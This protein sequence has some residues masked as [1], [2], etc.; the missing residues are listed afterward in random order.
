MDKDQFIER[1]LTGEAPRPAT[2]SAPGAPLSVFSKAGIPK[3]QRS[4][5][6]SRPFAQALLEESGFGSGET[7]PR[8]ELVLGD[9][10]T[11]RFLPPGAT[12][13][14]KTEAR[15]FHIILFQ[16][17][18]KAREILE[19]AFF[20]QWDQLEDAV[21]RILQDALE[22][23][24]RGGGGRTADRKQGAQTVTLCVV[25]V[26][27]DRG[28]GPARQL[29]CFGTK[30]VATN[31][32]EVFTLRE[33]ARDWA[34]RG[35]KALAVEH[36]GQLFKR[37]FEPLTQGAKWQDAFVSGAERKKAAALV[38]A[39][40]QPKLFGEAEDTLRRAVRDLL[41]EIAWSFGLPRRKANQN[42]CLDTVDLPSNH[43]IAVDPDESRRPGFENP[44]SGMRVYDASE[45]LLGFIVYFPKSKADIERLQ[46]E[47]RTHNHF[48]N[49]LVIYPG[50]DG[51]ELELW[52]GPDPLRGRLVAGQRRSRFDGEGGI[53]QLFSR[54]FVVSKSAIDTPAQLA[55]ELAWRG[56]HLKALA[57]EELARE[58]EKGSGPLKKLF[59]VFNQALATLTVNQFADA[60]A[61][62]ITYGMLAARWL[63]TEGTTLLFTRKNLADLLPSTSAFLH[64]LFQR[65]VNSNFDK[66][67]SWLLDDITSLLA[68]TSVAQVFQGEQDPSI[69]FYQDFLDAYDP[70][71]RKDQGVYYTPDEVVSYIVRTAHAA[72]QEQFG[73]PLGLADTTTWADFAKAKKLR[74]PDGVPPKE[75]FVQILDPATGTGTFLLRVIEVVHETM[76]GEYTRQGL[77]E[78]PAQKA[79]LAYVREHLLPRINGFELMMAPYI[80][81]HLRLGLALQQTGFIFQKQDRL[82]VYLTNTLEMHTSHQLSWIGEHV[83]EEA[84]EADRVK[85][86]APISV[87]IGNPPY[88]REPADGGGLHKGG[89]VRDGWSGWRDGRALLEDYAEP[90][91]N[92]GAGGHLKNIY[93]LYVYF[94]RWATWRVFD[95]NMTPGIVS[96]IT[97]SSY[98]RGPGFS[99]VRE[100]MRRAADSIWILDLEG[101]Q[102][103]TRITE[104]VFC[105]TIPVCVSSLVRSG[106]PA[107]TSPATTKYLRVT[108]TRAEKL[109]CAGGARSFG[110]LTWSAVPSGM[111]DLLMA[112]GSATYDAWPAVTDIFPWQHSGTQFKRTWPIDC[113]PECL[114]QRWKALVGSPASKRADMF[115][116]S[117]DRK[118]TG[119][120]PAL[121]AEGDRLR[122]VSTLNA[123]S[124]MPEARRFAFR[125]FDRQ[126][127]IADTRVGD[128]LRPVLWQVESP[129]QTFMTS[130]LAGLVGEGPAA[131]ASAFVP[132][133]HHFRGSYGGKDAIPLWRD[134]EC[135]APNVAAALMGTLGTAYGGR[136]KPEDV[137]AYAYAV[138]A[139]PGYVTRFEED[140]QIPGPRIPITKSRVLFDRGAALGHELLRWHTYG[141]RY[142]SKGDGFKLKGTARVK[143]PFLSTTDGYPEKHKYDDKRQILV[144]GGGEVG[145]VAPEVWQFSVSG[146]QVVK[147]WLDYRMKKGA[148]KKSSPL[149]EIRPEHWT[150]EMTQELMELLWVLEWTVAQYPKLDAWLDEVL[151][152]DLF[153]AEQIP[154]PTDAERKE[155]KVDR[156]GQGNL[157][158]NEDE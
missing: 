68:R 64:D 137:F 58:A 80:V 157:L 147:S 97:A 1:I 3:V 141:E 81:S 15:P 151:A 82:R 87:V 158:E 117:R 99:G 136:P 39:C 25:S 133:L 42:R 7:L 120:Y 139:N 69:H 60:Y 46:D 12:Y 27:D 79:W 126:W 9:Q 77:D 112:G 95:R 104:N 145:P 94:W 128:Y 114:S 71:I 11:N 131:T 59:D 103:G 152:S 121:D 4:A 23:F 127:C 96:F 100:E 73:L 50:K 130:L 38:A 18:L 113:D 107:R 5:A 34:E 116:E 132:D 122:S 43:S 67:L 118:V 138:L 155:P 129:G 65:L 154:P 19:D 78:G 24:E 102:R 40:S 37:H 75:P 124:A 153:T 26:S 17:D 146:L 85:R 16:L 84:K 36:L 134:A 54:F 44:L 140:L 45:R 13:W 89:W 93:N 98:L 72:L 63:S 30:C 62:T 149:D 150:D 88:E 22:G 31:A 56:R 61:Q 10:K 51:P 47:L 29:V 14:A 143:R 148:G 76:K 32:L 108:G 109:A 92:A 119:T 53:V 125:S 123:S 70:Q 144:I 83:A 41:D 86:E 111:Q 135:R 8:G 33:E 156:G 90:T 106:T 6:S 142:R 2:S 74:V 21:H 28:D 55:A 49:V 57:V 110:D 48:H 101:D 91:R 66:N 20:R 115:R 35:D 52:Q 105:I